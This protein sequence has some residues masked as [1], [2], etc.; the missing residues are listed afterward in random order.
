MLTAGEAAAVLEVDDCTLDRLIAAGE[1]HALQTVSGNLRVCKDSLFAE[2]RCTV[3]VHEAI[4]PKRKN[5]PA[6]PQ[7]IEPGD[8]ED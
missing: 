7:S 1:V 5:D 3:K 2:R 6:C 8:S 4:R